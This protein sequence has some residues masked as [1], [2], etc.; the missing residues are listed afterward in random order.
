V[1]NRRRDDPARPP[2][3]GG[4][5]GPGE[6]PKAAVHW[7]RDLLRTEFADSPLAGRPGAAPS[8]EEA[9]S[10]EAE[11]G[12]WRREW[13][14][15][16]RRLQVPDCL[17]S[18][19]ET[20]DEARAR[21]EVDRAFAAYACTVVGAYACVLFRGEGPG[22]PLQAAPDAHLRLGD[23]VLSLDGQAAAHAGVLRAG[24]LSRVP[25]AEG[26]RPLFERTGAVAVMLQPYGGGAVALV[27]RR[28]AREFEPLDGRL[29]RTLAALAEGA[30]ARV[31]LLDSL[32]G[33]GIDAETRLQEAIRLGWAGVAL[34]FPVTLLVLRA[35]VAPEHAPAAPAILGWLDRRLRAEVNDAGPIVPFGPESFAVVLHADPPTTTA[36]VQRM[37]AHVQGLAR[38]RSAILPALSADRSARDL[39]QWARSEL[40]RGD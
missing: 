30:L 20:L 4:S 14:R 8:D 39:M 5:P 9:R 1:F 22:A 35:T 7:L 29:L 18:Y 38:L 27:E 32:D 3:P 26:L 40:R 36:L 15:R 17:S 19:S 11:V 2:L 12:L 23:A 24:D 31:R 6:L 21:G 28:A 33:A 34:G 37:A 10:A 25:G 13:R 16:L